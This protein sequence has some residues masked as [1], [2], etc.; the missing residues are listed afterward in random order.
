MVWFWILLRVCEKV[1][2]DLGWGG[3]FS[4]LKF[5]PPFTTGKSQFSLY[6]AESDENQVSKL[7]M[8]IC[9]NEY[10]F[11]SRNRMIG[12]WSTKTSGCNYKKW[13]FIRFASISLRK[14]FINR[15][16]RQKQSVEP[17]NR[18]FFWNTSKKSSWW[19]KLRYN[20]ASDLF[21]SHVLVL[22]QVSLKILFNRN[23]RH[24]PV[25]VHFSGIPCAAIEL[26]SS[27]R[28]FTVPIAIGLT[29]RPATHIS[30]VG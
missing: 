2:Y 4:I 30:A 3:V 16:P 23:S 22:C 14:H 13:Q 17:K 25:N 15:P 21:W 8:Q 18:L 5:P 29:A 1:V 10:F 12:P 28:K 9:K 19:Q 20:S 11:L 7:Q 6:M 26:S 27:S 24:A